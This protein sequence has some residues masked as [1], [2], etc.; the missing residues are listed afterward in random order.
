MKFLFYFNDH[1]EKEEYDKRKKNKTKKV[2]KSD[3]IYKLCCVPIHSRFKFEA[4][5]A[6]PQSVLNIVL[7]TRNTD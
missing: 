3:L 6:I 5:C 1:G 2:K 4:H 7:N